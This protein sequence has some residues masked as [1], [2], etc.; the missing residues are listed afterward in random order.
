MFVTRRVTITLLE[1]CLYRLS[2]TRNVTVHHP[3]CILSVR[4]CFKPMACPRGHPAYLCEPGL[5]GDSSE[6]DVTITIR[7]VQ[8]RY[9]ETAGDAMAPHH[10]VVSGVGILKTTA[11]WGMEAEG[12]RRC[13]TGCRWTKGVVLTRLRCVTVFSYRPSGTGRIC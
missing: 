4:S 11:R 3:L 9:G 1:L 10:L 8:N 13:W 7:T 6:T 5:E 12:V 2:K